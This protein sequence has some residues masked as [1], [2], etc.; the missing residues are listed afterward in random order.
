MKK[1]FTNISL[2]AI[3]AVLLVSCTKQEVHYH[4]GNNNWLNK[5]YGVVVYSDIYCPY[6]VVETYYGYTIIRASGYM[7]YEGD[8]IYVDL[9]RY[10]YRD[11]YNYTDN[12]FI[13]GDVRE[14]WLSYGEAQ[15]MIDNLCYT[16][17]GKSANGST[18]KKVIKQ[19]LLKKK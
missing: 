2:V 14:Y 18:E 17:Y 3:A 10:G 8:E 9:S 19:G 4:D 13:R 11:F 12:S 1:L 15:Y 16:Y 5:E 7:P 6:F